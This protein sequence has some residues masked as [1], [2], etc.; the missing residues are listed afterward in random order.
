MKKTALILAAAASCLWMPLAATSVHAKEAAAN[1]D[2][3]SDDNKIRCRKI[4][5]TGSLVRKTKVCKTVAEWR[6]ISAKGNQNVRDIV[7]SGQVCAGGPQCNG[8]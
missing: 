1:D 4:E 8:G 6:E 2:A 5:V 7:E 3:Q